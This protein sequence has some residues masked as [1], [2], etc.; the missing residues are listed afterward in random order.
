MVRIN[1]HIANAIFFFLLVV[2]FQASPE[3]Q[4]Y[5]H[6]MSGYFPIRVTA[7]DVPWHKNGVNNIRNSRPL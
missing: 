5:W 3:Q 2:E 4:A 1:L 7:Y 6:T